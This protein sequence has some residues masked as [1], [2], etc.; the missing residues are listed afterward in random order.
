M[1]RISHNGYEANV[2]Y[3]EDDGLFHGEVANIRDVITFQAKTEADLE[4]ALAASLDDYLAFCE[5]RDE[6]PATP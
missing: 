4:A 5:L 3:D 2:A 6:T 1:R